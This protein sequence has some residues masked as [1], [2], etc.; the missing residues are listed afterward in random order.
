MKRWQLIII[1]VVLALVSA[2]GGY[3]FQQF[4]KK[5]K[6]AKEVVAVKN[7]I[8]PEEVIGTKVINFSLLDVDGVQRNLSDWQGKV[9]AINFWATWCTPCREEIPA[10]VELQEQYSSYGLQFIGV[11]LQEADEIRD[12][13]NEFNVNYPALV[14]ANDVMK[15]AKQLGN[16]I[17]ALPYTVIVDRN[18]IISFTRRGP[19]SKTE[20]EIVIQELL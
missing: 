19:L 2:V 18:G 5:D 6:E 15:A 7:P 16:D 11:A 10:F 20:A 9:L 8:A 12:F 17:G 4:I 13:L 3:Q 1:I 14:G